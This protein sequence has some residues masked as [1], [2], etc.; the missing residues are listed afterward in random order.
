MVR[1]SVVDTACTVRDLNLGWAEIYRT[2]PDWQ[3]DPISI[4]YSGYRGCF[5]EVER[6]GRRVDHP[7]SSVAEVKEKAELY[8]CSPSVPSR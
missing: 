7:P 3:R 5:P 8:V 4:L 2:R 6:S 1:D